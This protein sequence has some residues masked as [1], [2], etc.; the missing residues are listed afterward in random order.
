MCD[1]FIGNLESYIM[2]IHMSFVSLLHALVSMGA[3]LC[4]QVFVGHTLHTLVVGSS[5]FNGFKSRQIVK[6]VLNYFL[7]A[8]IKHPENATS[9]RRFILGHSAV[10]TRSPGIG[11]LKE[12]DPEPERSG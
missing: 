3:G 1:V 6:R 9:G 12:L 10:L 8:M 7:V 11:S 4:D 2:D 5:T